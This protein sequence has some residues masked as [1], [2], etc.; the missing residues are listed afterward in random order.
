[1]PGGP[2][3]GTPS[4]FQAVHSRLRC[5]TSRCFRESRRPSDRST[6]ASQPRTGQSRALR[7]RR[8]Q[9]AASSE[10]Q[11]QSEERAASQRER[12][13]RRGGG[14]ERFRSRALRQRQQNGLELEREPMR[15]GVAGARCL[16]DRLRSGGRLGLRCDL[17]RRSHARRRG[18]RGSRRRGRDW[19]RR[20]P[21]DGAGRT[22]RLR[23][24][25]RCRIRPRPLRSL[26]WGWRRR[27]GR[28]ERPGL[29]GRARVRRGAGCVSRPRH[30][31]AKDQHN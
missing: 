18:P 10:P 25:G 1:M 15:L 29:I 8:I 26:H 27:R 13:E 30:R 9:A 21:H 20:R 28:F 17:R 3:G 23:P 5:G 22:R 2:S 19:A 11:R 24:R 4:L 31:G 12:P 14:K 6:G 7:L 16:H